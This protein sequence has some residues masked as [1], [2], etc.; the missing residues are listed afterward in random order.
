MMNEE[1]FDVKVFPALRV[2]LNCYTEDHDQY[3]IDEFM[4]LIGEKGIAEFI[5]ELIDEGI[6]NVYYCCFDD[7]VKV[8]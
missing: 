3:N 4:D 6:L 1:D 2:Y 8:I 7:V 5:R